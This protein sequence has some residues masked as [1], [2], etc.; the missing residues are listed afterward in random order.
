MDQFDT[1]ILINKNDIKLHRQW[2]KEL[3]RMIGINILYKAPR[4]DKTYDLHGE[5]LSHYSEPIKVG[6]I[7]EDHPT[8]QTMK[9]LGWT[10]ELQESNSIIHL[11]DDLPD[12]Q[13]GALVIVP[14]GQ[15]ST[16]GRVF[17]IIKMSTIAVYSTT[18]ACEIGPVF[19][20][21]AEPASSLDYSKTSNNFIR[22]GE[23]DD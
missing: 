22:V 2:F 17:K 20:S 18:V 4:K 9:R 21:D 8:Q 13:I 15:D 12:L 6:C 10:S 11:P 16:K 19:D 5:L 14:S 1:G 23:E 7:F 3:C